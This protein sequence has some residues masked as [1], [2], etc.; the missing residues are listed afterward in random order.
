MPAP[1]TRLHMVSFVS[2]RVYGGRQQGLIATAFQWA[3][4]SWDSAG[5]GVP[6]PP[7]RRPCTA[8]GG[9]V[10]PARPSRDHGGRTGSVAPI[11]CPPGRSSSR[12]TVGTRLRRAAPPAWIQLA[13]P[14]RRPEMFPA[15][16]YE[17]GVVD[18]LV[19]LAWRAVAAHVIFAY[20]VKQTR[21]F[22]HA[23]DDVP[24]Y[25]LLALGMAGVAEEH[26]LEQRLTRGLVS[27]GHWGPPFGVPG[28]VAPLLR[29]D[30]AGSSLQP[31][32]A[33]EGRVL[34]RG[35]EQRME[36]DTPGAK[37]SLSRVVRAQPSD[38]R[39]EA[40]REEERGQEAG[41][42]RGLDSAVRLLRGYGEVTSVHRMP[43]P[44]SSPVHLERALHRMGSSDSGSGRGPGESPE[45]W[46]EGRRHEHR[47]ARQPPRPQEPHSPV[48]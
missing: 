9:P 3:Q 43:A 41:V 15:R 6:G 42:H 16:V 37:Y 21:V 38:G 44:A 11:S 31:K 34:T 46:Q 47:A 39:R 14:E 25:L 1:I 35:D 45:A 7:Y 12:A 23:V 18:D 24:E 28:V 32:D 33:Q 17:L 27:A 40:G 8:R 4:A 26:L 10:P 5:L 19:Y 29:V 30:G 48:L 2:F 13:G 22:I 20:D 36:G